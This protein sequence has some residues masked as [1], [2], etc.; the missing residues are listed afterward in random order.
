M[1]R[2]R[3]VRS[4]LWSSSVLGCCRCYCDRCS[5]MIHKQELHKKGIKQK[6][7]PEGMRV[8]GG[9]RYVCPLHNNNPPTLPWW[10]KTMLCRVPNEKHSTKAVTQ[11]NNNSRDHRTTKGD[12]WRWKCV[13]NCFNKTMKSG[14]DELTWTKGTESVSRKNNWNEGGTARRLK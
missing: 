10:S 14:D 2:R 9:A 5:E 7:F 8:G 4:S 1:K 12:F 6:S 11:L 3:C 13:W